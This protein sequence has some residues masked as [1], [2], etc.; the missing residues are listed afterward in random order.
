MDSKSAHQSVHCVHRLHKI[1]MILSTKCVA[2]LN[3]L[4][5]PRSGVNCVRLAKGLFS[6]LVFSLQTL[7]L[8]KQDYANRAVY[9][10]GEAKSATIRIDL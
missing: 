8:P 10:L 7:L 5:D 9:L 2:C 6:G 1:G 3:P 4:G